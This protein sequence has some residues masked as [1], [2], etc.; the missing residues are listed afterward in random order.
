LYKRIDAADVADRYDVVIWIKPV[1]TCAIAQLLMCEA[2]AGFFEQMQVLGIWFRLA[3][4]SCPFRLDSRSF[5]NHFPPRSI[6]R[7]T[8]S[9]RGKRGA[10]R[11]NGR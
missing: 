5:Q 4:P 10:L 11:M 8:M 6:P 7:A 9:G 3:T 2:C 1:S